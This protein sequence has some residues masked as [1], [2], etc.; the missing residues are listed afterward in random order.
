MRQIILDTETT[1]IGPEQGHRVIEIGCIELIDRK[2]T[3]KHFHV[4]LNPQREVDEGAFRVHGIST[5]FLQDKPLFQ[6]IVTEFLQF[7]EGSELIIHN[8]PFDVGFLNSELNHVKWNKTLEDYCQ[9]LDTL[10]LA[11]EKHPGQR[12]SLDAL[13]K[14]Y[15]IDHFN[16]ELHGALLDAEIL[17]YVYLAMTGGQSSLFTEVESSL[18]HSKIKTQEI[19][20]LSLKN[21]VIMK[22]NEVELIQHQSFI[23]FISKKSG[24]NH[25][26]EV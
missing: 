18:R 8:A 1:G 26:E 25:W 5:E 17:A 10:V 16:R 22:A 12:N 20:P 4:Y 2:L 3:G 13:C 9:I 11:R 14:R 21:P 7:V 23:E 19:K 15:E 24:I 6:D